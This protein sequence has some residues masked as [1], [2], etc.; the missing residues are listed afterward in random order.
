MDYV[1]DGPTNKR[2][3]RKTMTIRTVWNGCTQCGILQLERVD[4]SVLHRNS[5]NKR[6]GNQ[7]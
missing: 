1:S 4:L 3:H 2:V 5:I 7:Q 6:K